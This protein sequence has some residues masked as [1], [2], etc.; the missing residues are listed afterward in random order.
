MSISRIVEISLS[1]AKRWHKGGIEEWSALEW[2]GATCGEAGE[3][4]NAAKKLKLL[5]DGIASVNE[6]ER[7]LEDI[8][9]AQRV[10]AHEAIDTILYAFL[11]CNR[12]GLF[13][14]DVEELLV[15]VFNQKS[16]EYGF[17]ERI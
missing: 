11:L 16:Q 7:N 6:G 8:K 15:D 12:V 3:A 14:D 1:R 4:A 2:A 17:P 5:E 9:S 10:V 13:G